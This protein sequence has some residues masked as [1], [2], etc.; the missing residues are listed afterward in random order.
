MIHHQAR[1]HL[2]RAGA[3][4]LVFALLTSCGTA[5]DP[6]PPAAAP[7]PTPAP[8]PTVTIPPADTA[9]VPPTPRET[10]P[11][12][13][14]VPAGVP[15][16]VVIEAIGVDAELVEL[17]LEPDGAMEVPDFGL[18]GW[19]A[20]GPPPGHPGP[21]VIAAHVDSRAGPDVFYRLRELSPGDTV[22][23]SYD[24]GDEVAFSVESSER[25]PKDDLPGDRIW[26]VTAD[27]LLTLI[28]C[29]GE[30]DR[31]V[32]HYRDNVIVYTRPADG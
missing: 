17:G 24:G 13:S 14:P 10:T 6:P 18:A 16:R 8:T 7:A 19:Y 9:L 28:T 27:R 3:A 5:A 23:V 2:L 21:A 12:P 31:S 22:R 4:C 1:R 32:R 25:V 26:P 20:E 11:A 15:T 30:F 29:G